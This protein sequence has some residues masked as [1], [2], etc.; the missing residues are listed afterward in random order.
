VAKSQCNIWPHGIEFPIRHQEVGVKKCLLFALV[1]MELGFFGLA[2]AALTIR[3]PAGA[4]PILL[5]AQ[6]W[7]PAK[8]PQL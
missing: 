7:R 6:V 1:L 4:N 2:W 3:Q 8:A 5:I